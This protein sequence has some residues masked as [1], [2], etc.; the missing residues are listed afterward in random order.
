MERTP[1][2]SQR[3][4][5]SGQTNRS[6]NLDH[7]STCLAWPEEVEDACAIDTQ[8]PFIFEEPSY[9]VNAKTVGPEG[10]ER[11]LAYREQAVKLALE[12]DA[13]RRERLGPD[14]TTA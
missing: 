7:Y 3:W 6:P 5:C 2:G 11:L 9:A 10:D 8:D 4:K 1:S 12:Y 13:E 14:G